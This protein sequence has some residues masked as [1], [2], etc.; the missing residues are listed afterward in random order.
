[1]LKGNLI[2]NENIL[3]FLL[4]RLVH[5]HAPLGPNAICISNPL[6]NPLP[7]LCICFQNWTMKTLLKSELGIGRI[8]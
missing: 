4:P 6:T 2:I 8:G 7:T 3:I 5:F 1:M